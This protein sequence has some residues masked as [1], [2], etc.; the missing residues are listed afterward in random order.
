MKGIFI[1][2]CATGFGNGLARHYLQAGWRV[3]ATDRNLNR[4]AGLHDLPGAR[5]RLLTL[6]LDVRDPAQV[7]RAV[8]EAVR[9]G[10]VDVLVN[11]A[12]FAV[13][14][15]QEEADLDAVAEML[16]VNILGVARVTQALLPHLRSVAGTVVNISSVAGQMSFPESGFYAA[17]KH[18][19][20]AM[21]EALYEETASFGMRVVL[22]QPGSFD[23]Q[24]LPTAAERSLPRDPNGPYAAVQPTWDDVKTAVLEPPQSASMVVEAIAKAV[25][26][27]LRFQRVPVGPDCE[28]ILREVQGGG[29]NRF[30]RW[31]ASASSGAPSFE[32]RGDETTPEAL[33]H[34]LQG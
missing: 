22:M 14:G 10:P 9:T 28:R 11:N 4:L 32:E 5:E 24:F 23:T 16:D 12:G 7:S 6:A 30:T 13:F 3:V 29:R 2:G 18:A 19:V 15:T 21:S 1:T 26:S 33:L 34:S 20:E 17:S 8:D 31:L 25:D 27:P